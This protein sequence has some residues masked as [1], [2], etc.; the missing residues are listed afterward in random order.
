VT[1]LD[2]AATDAALAGGVVG[3]VTSRDVVWVDGPDA[4]T[5]LQGQ[6][7]QDLDPLGVGDVADALVLSPQGKLDAYVAVAVAAPERFAVAV[8]AG[9][10]EVLYERLRR[11]KLRVK[12]TLE[13]TTTAVVEVRGP[14]A[15]PPP[16]APDGVLVLGYRFGS[17]V[18]YDLLGDGAR[19][20]EGVAAG[21][22][23]AFEVARILAGVPRMGHE[24]T[25]RTIPQE[26]G[27]VDR[28]VSFSKGCYTG[29]ELVA[30]LD[31]R[32]N[33]VPWRLRL[34]RAAGDVVAAPEDELDDGEARIGRITSAAYSPVLGAT[35]ALGYLRREFVP[36]GTVTLRTAG[37]STAAE[38][39][40]L[41]DSP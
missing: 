29:Q 21:D 17:L 31:A 13:L 1:A 19:L 32:G 14:L 3:R 10:G 26:A 23:G 12:A 36:P 30:R 18:G 5:Y 20:P 25:E 24:L 15:T 6:V 4:R 28:A 37:G 8:D 9:F 39:V 35:V 7:S 11:F 33:R 22:E 40:A 38:V 27:L 34:V 41:A 16:S 2:F